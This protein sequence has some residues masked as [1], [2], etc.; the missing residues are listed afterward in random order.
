MSDDTGNVMVIAI[1][2]RLRLG[3]DIFCIKNVETFV[4]HRTHIEVTDC[5]HH[6]KVKIVF[7]TVLHF[8]PMHCLFQ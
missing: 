5:N 8:V 1:G 2:R 6:V 3:K 4:L 7:A